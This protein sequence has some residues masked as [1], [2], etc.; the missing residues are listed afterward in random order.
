MAINH[1]YIKKFQL[2]ELYIKWFLTLGVGMSEVCDELRFYSRNSVYLFVG[3]YASA[4]E[5]KWRKQ[6]Q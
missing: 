6:Q 5:E 2:K 3:V 1:Q 4:K